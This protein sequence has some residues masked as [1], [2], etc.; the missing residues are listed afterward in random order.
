MH[1]WL[2]TR[3]A[4][5]AERL[6]VAPPLPPPPYP[7]R[8]RVREGE[9]VGRGRLPEAERVRLALGAARDGRADSDALGT[10]YDGI[11]STT[12]P[13]PPGLPTWPPWP[14]GAA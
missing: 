13:L 10:L 5:A 6:P 7:L 4:R 3:G 14:T 1:A 9:P 11:T 8:L 2:D 12:R